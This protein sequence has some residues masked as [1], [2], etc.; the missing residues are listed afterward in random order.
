[1]APPRKDLPPRVRA[2]RARPLL[3]AALTGVCLF[4]GG[5]ASAGRLASR[6]ALHAAEAEVRYQA[7]VDCYADGR[8]SEAL[9]A[10]QDALRLNPN[11]EAARAAVDRLR[12]EQAR[13]AAQRPAAASH[14]ALRRM[15]GEDDSFVAKVERY[16]LFERTVG[17]ARNQQGELLAK[18]GRIAQLLVERKVSRALRRAFEKDAELHALS[19]RL[20]VSMS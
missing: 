11:D 18:Q 14:P 19:R 2:G 20:P 9:V 4:E 5:A 16:L 7:G 15:G 6:K 3:L 1:M 13:A 17:D 10:F 8:F 12:S